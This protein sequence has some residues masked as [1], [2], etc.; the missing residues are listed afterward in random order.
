MVEKT[1]SAQRHL[2]HS[3]SAVVLDSWLS[4][5]VTKRRTDPSG[6]GVL[7]SAEDVWMIFGEYSLRIEYGGILESYSVCEYRSFWRLREEVHGSLREKPEW[8]SEFR[9]RS[10]TERIIG[11]PHDDTG[12]C[13]SREVRLVEILEL[14]EATGERTIDYPD[15]LIQNPP[16][17][18]RRLSE[19][20]RRAELQWDER[21]RWSSYYAS[22]LQLL[23]EDSHG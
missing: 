16:N 17:T 15:L 8:L 19:V 6:L 9:S 5:C 23:W 4:T 10:E 7:M 2:R 20:N 13:V 1:P 21:P 11:F 12:R 14:L 22:D 18:E 3:T